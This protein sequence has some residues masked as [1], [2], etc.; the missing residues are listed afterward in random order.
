MCVLDR[1]V[2]KIGLSNWLKRLK[3]TFLYPIWAGGGA[4][5]H[6]EGFREISQ[7]RFSQSSRKFMTFKTI[8]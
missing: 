8:I 3:E 5:C 1:K 4:K 6:R 2:E 7:K